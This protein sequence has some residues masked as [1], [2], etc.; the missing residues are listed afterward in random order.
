M[1]P[2]WGNAAVSLAL[3][4][5]VVSGQTPSRQGASPGYQGLN[6]VCPERCIVSGPNPSNWSA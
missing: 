4:A 1:A 6:S 2:F 5:A 3:S